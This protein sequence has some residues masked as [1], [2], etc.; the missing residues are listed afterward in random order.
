VALLT[1][2]GRNEDKV[3]FNV[4]HLRKELDRLAGGAAAEKK[5]TGQT[6]ASV[7]EL[8]FA[9]DGS[10]TASPA[11]SPADAPAPKPLAD[12]VI[13]GPAPAP[14]LRAETFY[15]YQIMLRTRQMSELSRRLA[16]LTAS[17]A[18]PDDLTLTVDID[19]V[20]LS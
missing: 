3:K 7:T 13:C 4:D 20:N 15:R 2:K 10:A 8:N 17:L 12:L 16:K 11:H 9:S 18:L 1:L 6:K 14:L 5:D 19:P